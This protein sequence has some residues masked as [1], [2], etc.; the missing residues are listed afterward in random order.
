MTKAFA[1]RMALAACIVAGIGA[2][3]AAGAPLQTQP[4]G[5]PPNALQGFSQN[6]DKPIKINAA[7]LE[8]RE[9]EKL[10]LIHI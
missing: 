4:G 1:S 10:S 3:G 7:S 6:R 2:F 8:V 5:G 9:K